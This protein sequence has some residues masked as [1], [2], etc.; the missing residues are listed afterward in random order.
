MS[1]KPL[2]FIDYFQIIYELRQNFNENVEKRGCSFG[3]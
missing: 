3:M 1:E 2:F